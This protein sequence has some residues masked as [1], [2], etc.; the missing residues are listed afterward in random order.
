MNRPGD[1]QSNRGT[2]GLILFVTGDSPRSLRARANLARA[3]ERAGSDA[4]TMHEIDLLA[5]PEAIARHAIFATPA[6]MR[7]HGGEQSAVLYGDLSDPI[8]LERFL[9]EHSGHA[10][11]PP[12][13]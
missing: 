11:C 1:Q 6:L 7:M 10:E 9:G 2:D 8:A 4:E 12:A 3:L 5:D 13:P